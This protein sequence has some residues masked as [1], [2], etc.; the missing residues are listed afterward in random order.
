MAEKL[1]IGRQGG[2]VEPMAEPLRG[3]VRRGPVLRPAAEAERIDQVE[4]SWRH[5]AVMVEEARLEA[6][7][8]AVEGQRYAV[9][10][11]V[12][13]RSLVEE[14]LAAN[15]LWRTLGTAPDSA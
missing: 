12:L 1:S 6:L 10:A 11:D 4:L 5:R 9:P 13:S 3:V 7:T 15:A 14:H 2:A 8:A